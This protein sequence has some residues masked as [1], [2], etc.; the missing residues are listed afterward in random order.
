MRKFSKKIKLPEFYNHLIDI[1]DLRSQIP[2]VGDQLMKT[3]TYKLY[4]FGSGFK[5]ERV[6][7]P[8]PCTVT[9][10]HPDHLWYQ[11]T[12]KLNGGYVRECYKL[13]EVEEEFYQSGVRKPIKM[14]LIRKD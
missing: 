6:A 1:S 11:V 9:Y 7:E 8:M 13:P 14:K 2:H 3:P 4:S 10:I 12:F 5:S